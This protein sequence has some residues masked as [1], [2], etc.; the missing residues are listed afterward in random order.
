[1]TKSHVN[2]ACQPSE[3]LHYEGIDLLLAMASR[4]VQTTGKLPSL[5]KADVDSAFRRVPIWHGHR[6][7]AWVV[8]LV[9]GIPYAAG[10]QYRHVCVCETNCLCVVFRTLCNTLWRHSIGA[11]LGAVG[12]MFGPH[13]EG[14]ADN[15][16]VKIR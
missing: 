14:V 2:K 3:H 7:A 6:F 5:W 9:L 12:R 11:L 15:T 8:F 13:R 16:S 10:P 4:F 1:M